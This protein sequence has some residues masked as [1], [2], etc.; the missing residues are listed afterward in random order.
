[1]TTTTC[2][3]VRHPELY[4]S[5]ADF[6]EH[7]SAAFLS[8]AAVSAAFWFAGLGILV[9]YR[10]V[11]TRWLWCRFFLST[12]VCLAVSF[13]IR[14][15]ILARIDVLAV[16]GR[17]A[18]GLAVPAAA[19]TI[20]LVPRWMNRA[21]PWHAAGAGALLVA[22][23]VFGQVALQATTSSFY[24]PPIVFLAAMVV[25]SAFGG[26]LFDAA[27]QG[28]AR[29]RLVSLATLTI[30]LLS[31]MVLVF[32]PPPARLRKAVLVYGGVERFMVR[33]ILW[34]LPSRPL[35][36]LHLDFWR[37]DALSVAVPPIANP[38]PDV[39]IDGETLHFGPERPSRGPLPTPRRNAVWILVDTLRVDTTDAV[40]AMS[41]F[42]R[43]AISDFT[44]FR[45]YRSCGSMTAVVLS[46]LLEGK[47]GGAGLLHDL[48]AASYDTVR[49]GAFPDSSPHGFSRSFPEEPDPAILERSHSWLATRNTTSKPFFAFVHLAGGHEPVRTPGPTPRQRYQRTI[50]TSLNALPSFLAGLPSDW[51]VVISG[52]HGEAFGDHGLIGHAN[53]LYEELIETP[54]LVRGLGATPGA[55]QEVLGCPEM[56]NKLRRG[57][58]GSPYEVDEAPYRIASVDN[59]QVFPAIRQAALTVGSYKAIWNVDV[60]TWELYDLST[61]PRE[62]HDLSERRSDLMIPFVRGLHVLNAT[63][64]IY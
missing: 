57:L 59:T 45:N 11:G 58:S 53:G 39:A 49:F 64:Q 27:G 2:V 31:S 3:A 47:P 50:Q 52:D 30:L 44:W 40:L 42:V 19:A 17:W 61:D 13:V 37:H 29:G 16:L 21:L 46:Q 20:V 43:E 38:S 10:T 7:A 26:A 60:D 28:S 51:L 23:A 22:A 35:R 8:Y 56:V 62:R 54:F 18:Y 34:R 24:S 15:A 41:P 25:L 14:R 33:G 55:N 4:Q 5:T 32:R 36:V 6:V 1:V 48:N 9:A 63:G 12:F